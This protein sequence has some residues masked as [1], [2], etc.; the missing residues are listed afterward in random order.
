MSDVFQM[1]QGAL[2]SALTTLLDYL[3]LHVLLC[4][5]PAFFIA[6]AMTYFIPKELVTR[7]MGKDADPKIAY[8]MATAGGF[9]LAVCSCTVLPLFVGIWKRG[10]GLGPAI[11]FLFVAPAI[12][13][14]ALTYTGT[15]VG[16]DIAL[17]RG[18]LAIVFAF[19][20]GLIMAKV[21]GKEIDLT[22]SHHYNPENLNTP[23][24]TQDSAING[25][26]TKSTTKLNVVLIFGLGICSLLLATLDSNM[27]EMIGRTFF[28]GVPMIEFLFQ[29]PAILQTLNYV[30]GLLILGLTTYRLSSKELRLFLWLVYV[31]MTGTSQITYF[32]KDLTV[33]GILLTPAI[34][35]MLL[36]VVLTGIVVVGLLLF[37]WKMFEADDVNAW[38]LE[39]WIFVKSIFPLI[40]SGVV[41]A[42]FVKY[43][44]PPEIIVELVGSNTILANL[45]GVLFG[46]FMY[47]PTLMEVPIARIFLDLGMARGP[48]LAYLLADPELSI[49]SILVTRKYLGDRRNSFYVILVTF[50]TTFSG[51]LFG[52]VLGQG[53]GLW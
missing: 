41:I 24:K 28:V 50:F 9:L 8:P 18:I 39:T 7:Y 3:S 1:F 33:F 14:L 27:V 37:I 32:T 40:I 35:N 25:Q 45:I 30:L 23:S 6:G 34:S 16:M 42:G 21:F 20:I 46:V 49:Q 47:F 11:T 36:K 51:L 29:T 26:S 31:L 13:I 38:L 17:A 48:L 22:N 19:L 43:F 5:V 12:N 44:I 4:L 2:E 53:I 15:L 10:A 52:F